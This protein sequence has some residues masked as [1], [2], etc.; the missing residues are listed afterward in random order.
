M[1]EATA[2]T[3]ST[4]RGT[5]LEQS[6]DAIVLGLPGTDYRLHLVPT[7][8]ISTT[9]GRRITGVIHAHAMRVDIVPSG[10]RYI[11]PVYGR[12]RRLQ[13]RIIA[14]DSHAN[15][16]TLACAC[17]VECTL[18]ADQKAADMPIGAIASFD[19][20]PGATFEPIEG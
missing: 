11:E 17:A 1:T 18:T 9:V 2:S 10:G 7:A 6:D 20:K 13:G 14:T 4:T 16:I 5:L 12:P 8:L 3:G 15:S 19:V